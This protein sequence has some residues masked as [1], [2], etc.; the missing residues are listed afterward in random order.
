[1]LT[2]EKKADG[3]FRRMRMANQKRTK[4]DF[5]FPLKHWKSWEVLSYL[6]AR[7]IPIPDA[8]TGDSSAVDLIDY[9]II[10]LYRHHPADYERVRGLF[11]YTEAI[12]RRHEWFGLGERASAKMAS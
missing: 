12:V 3:P 5:Y 8:E 6:K 9:E 11:P 2:G 7:N 10:H 1:V 4:S